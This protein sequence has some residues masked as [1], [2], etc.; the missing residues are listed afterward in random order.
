MPFKLHRLGFLE[1]SS[2]SDL[3]A[4]GHGDA[5]DTQ[6]TNLTSFVD[7]V[8]KSVKDISNDRGLSGKGV[9]DRLFDLGV[10]SHKKLNTM[11]ERG[12][13]VLDAALEAGEAVMPTKLPEPSGS[14]VAKLQ[15]GIE[16]K[17]I[18]DALGLLDKAERTA[19]VQMAA[20]RGDGDILLAVQLAPAF[21]RD[22]LINED[23]LA[24]AKAR[25]FEVTQ[26]E[27]YQSLASIRESLS[28]YGSNVA[29][30]RKMIADATGT[31]QGE[32]AIEQVIA[33]TG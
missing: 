4:G 21:V 6:V 3:A 29:R 7:G 24:T 5:I 32:A 23:H 14:D 12:R 26:P 15:K 10:A 33:A 19:E 1:S 8:L 30:A 16:L 28:T 17:E 31:P 13:K 20:E 2:L 25:F 18:R 22:R 27:K 11:A 9:G